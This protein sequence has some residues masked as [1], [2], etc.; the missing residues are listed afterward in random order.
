VTNPL[1]NVL[2]H[3]VRGYIYAAAFLASL[4]LTAWQA[5]DGDWTKAVI[6]FLASL[7]AATAASNASPTPEGG[8]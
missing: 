8:E 5:A 1:V 6:A 7:I 3:K 2:N 4:A